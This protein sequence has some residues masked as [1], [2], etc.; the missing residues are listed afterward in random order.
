MLIQGSRF[1]K[2]ILPTESDATSTFFEVASLSMP[3]Q[4]EVLQKHLKDQKS[5][6]E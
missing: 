1:F 4:A 6:D 3:Q 2:V 5:L